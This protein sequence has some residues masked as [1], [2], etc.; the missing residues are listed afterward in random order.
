M[1]CQAKAGYPSD[2]S[3]AQWERV[4]ALLPKA[5]RPPKHARRAMV[6]AMLYLGRTGC[7]WRHLP[8]DFPPWG[9]VWEL[10]WR[11]RERGLLARIHATLRDACRTPT[12]STTG[13]SAPGERP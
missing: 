11:W 2:V 9:S 6:N 5:S 13:G 4:A 12:T 3:D 8:H 7:P 10:F 1:E